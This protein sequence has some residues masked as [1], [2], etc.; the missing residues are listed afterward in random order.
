M[1]Y[2]VTGGAGFIGSHL[3]DSLIAKGHKVVCLDNFITG[4]KKNVEHLV[5]NDSFQLVQASV[6]DDLHVPKVDGIFHLASPTDPVKVREYA[7]VTLETNI[8]GTSI[9]LNAAK[10]QN[11]SFL[12]VSSVRVFDAI[13]TDY[14]Y[15]KK[16]GEEICQAFI[17]KNEDVKITRLASVYGPRMSFDDGR[18]IPSFVRKAIA[19][20][21]LVV[22]D[23]VDSF[24]YVDDAVEALYQVMVSKNEG[25]FDVTTEEVTRI[26]DLAD[27]IVSLTNSNSKISVVDRKT[28]RHLLKFDVTVLPDWKHR[29]SLEEGLKRLITVGKN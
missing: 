2:L 8:V 29:V 3:C 18:V 6:T 16:I 1:K 14:S 26:V 13:L 9:L 10:N 25:T 15:A 19:G 24:C 7:S 12:F 20:T 5:N 27:T 22:Y 11:A 4:T 17:N 23:D 28:D 21:D